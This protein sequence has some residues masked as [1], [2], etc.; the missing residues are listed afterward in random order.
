MQVTRKLHMKRF[1]QIIRRA[2]KFFDTHHSGEI[3]NRFAEDVGTIDENLPLALMDTVQ[4][5][6]TLIGVL[7][8]ISI[9][10]YWL[11][12]AIVVVVILFAFSESIF[13]LISR[14]TN[15]IEARS[16]YRQ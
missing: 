7:I 11:I 16:E 4:N 2:M 1:Q 10:N 9:L 15:K 5:V 8:L 6:F 13:I 12:I 3:L 14:S